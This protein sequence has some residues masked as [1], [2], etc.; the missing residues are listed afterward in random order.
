MH[1]PTLLAGLA[2][3]STVVTAIPAEK[4]HF[5]VAILAINEQRTAPFLSILRQRILDREGRQAPQD[6]SDQM[7][8]VQRSVWH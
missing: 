6:G 8:D 3:F 4:P 5:G 1:F 7:P 2:A